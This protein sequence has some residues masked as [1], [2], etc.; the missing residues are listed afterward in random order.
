[1][2]T[3]F[4]HMASVAMVFLLFSGCFPHGTT[5]SPGVGIPMVTAEKDAAEGSDSGS[6]AE[7]TVSPPVKRYTEGGLEILDRSPLG[8]VEGYLDVPRDADGVYL[9]TSN[10]YYYY[11]E[12]QLSTI[13]GDLD[14]AIRHMRQAVSRDSDS[15]FL[16]KELALLY[17]H[18]KDTLRALQIVEEQ[19]KEKPDALEL[20]VL[21]GR[22]MQSIKKVPEAKMAFEKVIAKDPKRE[23]VYLFLGSLYM[24]EEDLPNAA[25]IY[26][27]LLRH[28]PLSYVGHFFLGKIYAGQGEFKAAE[29][30]FRR[31]LELEPELEEPRFELLDLYRVQG[32]DDKLIQE[33]EQILANNPNNLRASMALGYRYHRNDDVKKA[34]TIFDALGKRSLTDPD[35]IRKAVRYYLDTKSFDA[36]VV[37]F[38]G[39]LSGAP[40]NADL[41]YFAGSAYEGKKNPEMTMRHLRQVTPKSRFFKNAIIHISFV[42]REQGKR[43]E[44]I[45]NLESAIAAA[46]RDPVYFLYLGDIYE[47]TRELE[48]A[49]NTLRKGLEIDPDN[50][51]LRFRLGTIYDQWGMKAASLEEMKAVIQ[52]DP[53]HANALNYLGYT[54]ADSGENLDEAERLIKAALK[55]K[56]GDGYITDSLGWVYFKKGLMGKALEW[57][58]KAVVLVPNDPIILEHLGDVHLK[59]NNKTQALEFYN[60]SLLR[61][62][63]E[64]KNTMDL[65]KKIRQLSGK[66]S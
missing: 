4:H 40:E 60:R 52:I 44:A 19:L 45:R 41:H 42:L 31:A 66:D 17:L 1:M 25:R 63:D 38:E 39:M 65:E 36:A 32:K 54:Y 28:Y 6:S 46:P 56:P 9:S 33:Y 22:I 16:K 15:S 50:V 59:I 58:E 35:V 37:I 5:P 55:H 23:N 43:V 3:Y 53:Q 2:K 49:I 51:R 14:R 13:K 30:A 29:D 57:L 47:E 48:K 64:K 26:Q 8:P 7:S 12:A 24:T 61:M 20:L 62:Q 18:Q 21:Y 34:K 11:A 27:T 10:P